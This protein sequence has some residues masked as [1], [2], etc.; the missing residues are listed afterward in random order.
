MT[1]VQFMNGIRTYA[2]TIR[3]LLRANPAT[4]GLIQLQGLIGDI[5]LGCGN[6]LCAFAS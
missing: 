6:N 4:P 3:D 1:D 5:R 2:K